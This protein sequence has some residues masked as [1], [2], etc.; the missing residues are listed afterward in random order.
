MAS[1]PSL[2]VHRSG[3]PPGRP[4][5]PGA[6]AAPGRVQSGLGRV[7]QVG[8]AALLTALKGAADN[9]GPALR[10]PRLGPIAPA[11]SRDDAPMSEPLVQSAPRSAELPAS[12]RWTWRNISR[13]WE[14]YLMVL[15]PSCG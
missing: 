3:R 9:G 2:L 14:M 10:R 11:Q 5:N 7:G 1:T 13:N 15:L 6:A 8:G 12:R 4:R